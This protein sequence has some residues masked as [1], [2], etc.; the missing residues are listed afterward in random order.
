MCTWPLL[1]QMNL[2]LLKCSKL[3][4]QPWP[5]LKRSMMDI[6]T[7]P[8]RYASLDTPVRHSTSTHLRPTMSLWSPLHLSIVAGPATHPLSPTPPPRPGPACHCGRSRLP[9]PHCL[10]LSL[11]SLPVRGPAC[12]RGRSRLISSF[13]LLP[14]PFFLFSPLTLSPL[15]P[16]RAR[17]PPWEIQSD[18]ADALPS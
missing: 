4:T 18:L 17:R 7:S 13:L 2:P 5:L 14:S 12:H 10:P 16:R 3:M 8:R 9:L 1:T 15:L 11:L 6:S